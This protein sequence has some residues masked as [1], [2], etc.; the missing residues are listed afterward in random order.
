MKP[1]QTYPMVNFPPG[2]L[3]FLCTSIPSWSGLLI[4]T[5]MRFSLR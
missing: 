2:E 4:S 5:P 1:R 3:W